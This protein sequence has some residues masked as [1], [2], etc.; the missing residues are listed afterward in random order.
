[1]NKYLG[2]IIQVLAVVLIFGTIF[3]IIV[4]GSTPAPRAVPI[5]ASGRAI[6]GMYPSALDNGR[7]I[8]FLADDNKT[9]YEA[10]VVCYRPIEVGEEIILTGYI[11][12]GRH[13]A[14]GAACKNKRLPDK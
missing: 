5:A 6:E 10:F 12:R 8:L 3:R 1:M 9:S 11:D 13:V 2:Q 4:D 14:Y 7:W